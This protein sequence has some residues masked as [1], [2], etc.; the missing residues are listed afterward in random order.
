MIATP[1]YDN[2]RIDQGSLRRLASH[3]AAIGVTELSPRVLHLSAGQR[4]AG[5]VHSGVVVGR[6]RG[7]ATAAALV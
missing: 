1:L 2:L 5:E 7:V 4:H 6:R 3:H